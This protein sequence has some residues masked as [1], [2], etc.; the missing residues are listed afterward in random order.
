M[1][2][3]PLVCKQT[4]ES[5]EEAR[6]KW[7]EEEEAAAQAE[8]QQRATLGIV[9]HGVQITRH[10][11]VEGTVHGQLLQPVQLPLG[12]GLFPPGISFA[13]RESVLESARCTSCS[14]G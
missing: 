4:K 1:L 14:V 11:G 5:K 6:R 7:S 9:T 10:V 8:E 12:L 2:T 3:T 13:M